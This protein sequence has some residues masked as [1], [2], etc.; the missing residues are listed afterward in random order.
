MNSRSVIAALLLSMLLQAVSL[1]GHWAGNGNP[2]DAL[3]AVL[4]WSGVLHHHDHEVTESAQRDGG[5]SLPAQAASA[6]GDDGTGFEAFAAEFA[7]VTLHPG[8]SYH[9]D[10]SL[11]SR[12]HLSID[13]CVSVVGMIPALIASP[14]LSQSG[15]PPV[16][17]PQVEPVDPFLYGPL[18]P[19]RS[20]A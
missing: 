16:A 20:L 8:E 12:H 3:H 7:Q 18:R 17:G 5:A 13:A 10:H 6:G 2:A 14:D 1:G 9:Q 11:D 15:G 19:P 4:H